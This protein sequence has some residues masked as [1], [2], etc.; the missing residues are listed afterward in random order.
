MI[1]E[2]GTMLMTVAADKKDV[3]KS[4]FYIDEMLH[5]SKVGVDIGDEHLSTVDFWGVKR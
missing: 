1:R 3:D 5:A 2:A 4:L